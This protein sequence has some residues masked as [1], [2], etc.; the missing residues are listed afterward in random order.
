MFD[1]WNKV[2]DHTNFI[3]NNNL[4]D[5]KFKSLKYSDLNKIDHKSVKIIFNQFLSILR[6]NSVSD[7]SNAFDKMINLFIAKVYDELNEDTTFKV[8][9]QTINGIRFQYIMG[10][11]DDLSFLKDLMIYINKVWI[12]IWKKISL[13]IL[14]MKLMNYL[15]EIKIQIN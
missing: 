4:F 5:L 13:I 6:Q 9:N 12:F 8:N 2:W 1:K 3:L 10:V 14:M 11:D 15:I 7:K